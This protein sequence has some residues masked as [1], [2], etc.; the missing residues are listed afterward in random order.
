[1]TVNLNLRSRRPRLSG[2]GGMAVPTFQCQ[3]GRPSVTVG[4]P[5]T[6]LRL[7]EVEVEVEG[8]SGRCW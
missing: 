6:D 7:L 3:V 8:Q 5:G 2:V 1:M 4:R